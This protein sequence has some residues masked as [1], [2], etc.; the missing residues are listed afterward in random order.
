MLTVL[1][2]EAAARRI[3]CKRGWHMKKYQ[4][5]L[6]ITAALLLAAGCAILLFRMESGKDSDHTGGESSLQAR[7]LEVN[8]TSALVEALESDDIRK[9]S[10]PR[11]SFGITGLDDIGAEAGD[12]VNIIYTG[13][14][15]ETY[16]VQIR[17]VGWSVAEKASEQEEQVL[18]Q[19]VPVRESECREVIFESTGQ[20]MP[21][22]GSFQMAYTD[23][24]EVLWYYDEFFSLERYVDGSWEELPMLVSGLCG[25][26]GL[27]QID[28]AA[29]N[30]LE[31]DWGILYGALE[32]GIY[33]VE[34]E[35]FPERNSILNDILGQSMPEERES[36]EHTG[37]D[38]D[39]GVRVYAVFEIKDGLGISLQ[40]HDIKPDGLT[41]EFTRNGGSP[42]GEL[43]YG[44]M[45]WLEQLVDGKWRFVEYADQEYKAVWTEEAYLITETGST[46][47]VDWK[48]LY[49]ELPS[50]RYRFCKEVEDFRKA[51]DK[52][53]YRY[54]A[55]FEIE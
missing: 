55:E 32:P 13:E 34:K 51:G 29:P 9:D 18:P 25:T 54:Y 42:S 52:D 19:E 5:A 44:S 26:T 46:Q 45:Y 38:T 41:M 28:E 14:M 31:L 49:G 39:A 16:P 10:L 6:Y 33:C 48:W 43:L 21:G 53:S 8:E 17:A 36:L 47:E 4:K 12:I 50:G 15:M 1:G 30:E 37:P 2:M 20:I 22:G 7:I 3:K 24:H 27:W 40:V 35:V 11:Y 23:D